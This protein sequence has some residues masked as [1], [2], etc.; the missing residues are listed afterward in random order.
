MIVGPLKRGGGGLVGA[1]AAGQQVV[2]LRAK[3]LARTGQMGHAHDHVAVDGAE[4][5]K[6][7]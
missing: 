6:G 4:H 2:A 1:L 3:R 5:D 7:H